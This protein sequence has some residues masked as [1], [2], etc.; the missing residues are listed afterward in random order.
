MTNI[1]WKGSTLE[2]L[3]LLAAIQH[4]C[5]CGFDCSGARLSICAGHS[6]LLNDQRALDSLLRHRHLRNQLLAE[7][8][9]GPD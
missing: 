8:G 2:E 1:D 5:A 6:M 7:E 3:D 9:I 4:N